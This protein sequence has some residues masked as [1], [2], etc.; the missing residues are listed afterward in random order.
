MEKILSM[1][2][3]ISETIINGEI[4]IKKFLSIIEN[5]SF[6][7]AALSCNADFE[8]SFT[9]RVKQA[10]LFKRVQEVANFTIKICRQLLSETG[11]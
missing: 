10:H 1:V 4:S 5:Q 9:V 3:Y 7:E 6:F 8:N 11:I 2:R